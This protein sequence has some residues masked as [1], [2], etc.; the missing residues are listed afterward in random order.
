MPKTAG[1]FYWGQRSGLPAFRALIRAMEASLFD[2]RVKISEPVLDLGCGD[3]HFA[4]TNAWKFRTGIDLAQASLK[5]AQGRGLYGS[6]ELAD[7]TKMP[8][9]NQTF[10][11]VVSNCVVEHIP[12]V[13]AVFREAYRVLKPG[14]KFV[15]SVPTDRLN[16]A[17][18]VTRLLKGLGLKALET[19]YKAWFTR[20]QV[21]FHM[22]APEEW[23]RK[24]EAAG[25][26]VEQRIGYMSPR[27]AGWFDLLHFY[28]APDLIVRKLIGKWVLIPWRPLF[29]LEEAFAAGLVRDG[30]AQGATCC[31]FVVSKR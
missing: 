8:F 14:G 12:D 29:V 24:L 1:D 2:S 23:Q 11:T 27:A 15:L 10:Q 13:E 7:A 25:F 6:L 22:Y 18:T 16:E 17:L 31:F 3:G 9:A 4:E 19:R 28:G 30:A 26:T 21:H 5:E 20:M